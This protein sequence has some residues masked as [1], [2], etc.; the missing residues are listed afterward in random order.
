MAD[1]LDKARF[2]K[3]LLKPGQRLEIDGGMN[4][5]TAP[6]ARAAGIDWFVIGSAIFDTP[7]RKKT[8]EQFRKVLPK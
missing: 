5:V 4:F 2:L 1:Q 7:D 6:Q 8:I 3:P